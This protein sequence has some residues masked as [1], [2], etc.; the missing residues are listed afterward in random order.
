GWCPL[1]P[2]GAQSP[3]ILVEPPWTPA[4]LWDRVTLTCQG[5]GT[6][7]ATTWYKNGWT[8]WPNAPNKFTVYAEGI[9]ECDRPGTGR[10][11]PVSVVN[12]EWERL[13]LQVSAQTLLEGD[14]L[15]LRCRA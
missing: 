1:S 6:S 7:G 14:T 2:A 8:W 3:Q 9:Y 11:A 5:L 4:V 13:V 10:S 15:K 12:G